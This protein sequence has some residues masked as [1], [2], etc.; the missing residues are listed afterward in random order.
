MKNH[1]WTTTSLVVVALAATL[2]SL[3]VSAADGKPVRKIRLVLPDKAEPRMRK[4]A[5][6][7]GRQISQR[8]G[9]R[10]TTN[11][12]A[13]LRIEL[14]IRPDIG[15]EGFSIKKAEAGTIRIEGNDTRGVL[16]GVGK[17]LR[18]SRFDA[19][20]LT[21]GDWEGVSVPKKPIRRIYFATHFHNYYHEAPVEKIQRYVEDL[22]LW[23]FNELLVTYDMHHFNGFDDPE[24][25]A[26]RTRLRAILLAT[27][28]V[29]MDVSLVLPA[30]EGYANSPKEMRAQGGG[31]GAIFKCYVCPNKPGG[32]QYI[33]KV[34]GEEFDWAAD[35]KPRSI[36]IWPY[37]SGG[38]G[39]KACQPWGSRG[40]MKCVKEVGNLARE[41][42]PGTQIYLSTWFI[43]VNEWRGIKE[44][45]AQ[46]KGLVDGIV[47]EPAPHGLV[48]EVT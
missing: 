13:P 14:A 4:I 26:F 1:P 34:L 23:G 5:E 35:L 44:Q 21:P 38:C 45:L 2:P 3:P 19:N 17:F 24:A 37:D 30:N 11:G 27:K 39:C 25:V 10:V 15:K 28:R 43:K 22:A 42:I 47:S 33:L 29:G 40:F 46:D 8:C 20:G 32:M 18:T 31:R 6:V 7:F 41:K 12:E 48:V 9:A 36:W 16:Y